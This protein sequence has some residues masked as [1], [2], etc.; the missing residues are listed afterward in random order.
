[1]SNEST[2]N[3]ES[4]DLPLEYAYQFLDEKGCSEE[5]NKIRSIKDVDGFYDYVLK[6][7]VMFHYLESNDLIAEFIDV[8][9]P[10]AKTDQGIQRISYLKDLYVQYL[11]KK[12]SDEPTEGEPEEETEGTSSAYKEDLVNYLV[13]NLNIIESGLYLYNDEN[14]QTGVDFPVDSDNKYIDILAMDRDGVP[15]IIELKVS[16]CYE[17]AIGE[18][19]YYRNL[20]RKQFSK[21]Q[22]RIIIIARKI[23]ENLK[24]A[25]EEIPDVQLFEYTLSMKLSSVE[26]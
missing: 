24:L 4:R 3:K 12:D 17:S 15:V 2:L 5:S 20:I 11:K 6:K 22:V 19:L 9:W 18:A 10:F 13:D 25:A 16:E 21:D 23:T 14:G 1:M 26:E 8:Y 7:A